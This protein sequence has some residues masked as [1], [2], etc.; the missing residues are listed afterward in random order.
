MSG[1]NKRE[2]ISHQE[3]HIERNG[4]TKRMKT[5]LAVSKGHKYFAEIEE[6]AAPRA[7]TPRLQA[8]NSRRVR[9]RPR[10]GSH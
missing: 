1:I 8:A 10:G 7:A 4:W 9:L 2:R 6:E 5:V 3:I